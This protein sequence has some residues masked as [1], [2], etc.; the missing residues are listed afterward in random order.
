MQVGNSNFNRKDNSDVVEGFNS[1][2]YSEQG[3]NIKRDIWT[4]YK[5]MKPFAV[6]NFEDS[7][8]TIDYQERLDDI[9]NQILNGKKYITFDELKNNPILSGIIQNLDKD[10]KDKLDYIAKI[11]DKEKNN[12]TEKELRLILTV[13]D[14]FPEETSRSGGSRFKGYLF[15]GQYSIRGLCKITKDE[16]QDAFKKLFTKNERMIYFDKNKEIYAKYD[17]ADGKITTE[18]LN[19][20]VDDLVGTTGIFE[21]FPN[22]KS[23]ILKDLSEF[24]DKNWSDS[25]EEIK[26]CILGSININRIATGYQKEEEYKNNYGGNKINKMIESVKSNLNIVLD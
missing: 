25:F 13:L 26:G 8:L 19:S 17:N 16:L 14:A 1:P 7:S 3:N 22:M 12:I 11:E 10:A 24:L 9:V 4:Q 5:E 18:N 23:V 20:L 2:K 15:N 6:S 21:K